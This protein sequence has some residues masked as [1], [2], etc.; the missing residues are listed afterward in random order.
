M[1][2]EIFLK[3]SYLYFDLKRKREFKHNKTLTS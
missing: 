3:I 1:I 2:K